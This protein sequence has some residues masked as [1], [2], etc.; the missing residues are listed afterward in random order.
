MARAWNEAAL[1]AIRLDFPAP[2][3]HARNLYHLSAALWDV[4]AAFADGGETALFVDEPHRAADVEAARNDAIA[5]A[6]YRLLSQRY[7]QS[8]GAEETEAALTA[9]LEELC[10]VV[11]VDAYAGDHPDSAAAFG[12]KVGDEIL[13]GTLDDGSWEATDYDDPSYM[14]L[15]PP[16]VVAESGTV[17]VDP[18]RWQ[19]L[20]L[21]L[22]LSQNGLP[23][24]N[25]QQAF[26]GSHWGAVTPFAIDPSGESGVPSLDPGPPPR[27]A[28]PATQQEYRTARSR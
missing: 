26:V 8:L 28:V 14:P 27:I 16:L 3:V 15:N 17:M 24:P 21:E 9:T 7:R 11:D 5:F 2:T 12:L 4:W 20:L 25:E 19:P 1:S 22:S 23:L 13:A 10:G 6:S 18:D